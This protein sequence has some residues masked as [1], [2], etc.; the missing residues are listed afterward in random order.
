MQLFPSYPAH[1]VFFGVAKPK[2][3]LWRLL[4]GLVLIFVLVFVLT[5]FYLR[6]IAAVMPSALYQLADG[7]T[8][9][10]M[11]LL[12]FSFAIILLSIAIVARG[13]HQRPALSL[14][15]PLTLAL[16]QFAAV[17]FMLT[18][19][20]VGLL[21][22]MSLGLGDPLIPNLGVGAWLALLP[23]SMLAVLI[24]VSAEEVL[25]RGYIQQQLA[26]RFRSPWMWMVLPSVFFAIGHYEPG[27]AGENAILIALWA[28]V[29]GIMMADLT[30]RAGS[31]GPAIAVH[32]CNNILALLVVSLPDKLNGLSL[33]ISS[34]GM[35]DVEAMR[36]YLPVDF[37]QMVVFWLAA[38]LALRR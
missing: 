9:L 11:Y 38:R 30:A 4:I 16:P 25:F 6:M 12:M 3:E 17:F 21:A 33:F 10:S 32:F 37:A 35:E 36:A 31:L 18:V 23:L 1:T 29:F 15:G 7:E 20:S 5:Q 8:V 19:I 34:F 26:A 22:V 2:S 13:W 28:G 24:Q 27:I 14:L